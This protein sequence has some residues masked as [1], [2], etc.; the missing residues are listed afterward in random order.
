MTEIINKT[1]LIDI[2]TLILSNGLIVIR[3]LS[4]IIEKSTETPVS[5][6]NNVP[7]WQNNS[8]SLKQHKIVKFGDKTWWSYE[9]AA[10]NLT[11]SNVDELAF[12]VRMYSLVKLTHGDVV[13]GKSFKIST[14]QNDVTYLNQLA[15][16][17]RK[18]EITS[19]HQ[20]EFLPDLKL[21]TLLKDYLLEVVKIVYYKPSHSL[22]KLFNSTTT[23]K[24]IGE[25][26]SDI[27]VDVLNHL[28][29]IYHKREIEFSHPI[30][31]TNT[32]SSILK[33]ASKVIKDAED[34]MTRW[35]QLNRELTDSV[36]HAEI[37]APNKNICDLIT[38]HI[39][40]I[41]NGNELVE[42]SEFMDSLKLATYIYVLAFTGVRY[43]EALSCKVGC[44]DEID[45]LYSITATM[46]KTDN[47]KV[48][49]EWFCNQEVSDS[50][51][52]YQK[53]V[54]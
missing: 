17:L 31:P 32:L 13:G 44:V 46:T 25:K 49:M 36:Y 38:K 33:Y 48:E 3:P 43:N 26:T 24:L 53:Y 54:L 10:R 50:I 22:I 30:I 19:F 28:N 35:Q 12:Q 14:L 34:K 41:P 11:F 42:L 16:F 15:D 6:F 29:G 2:S 45:G 37:T 27:F 1:S 52:L 39:R 21:R 5:S 9:G 51:S 4:Q 7:L 23:F 8:L 47:T 40:N 18:R 20:L